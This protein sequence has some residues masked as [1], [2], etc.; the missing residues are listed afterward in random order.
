M[1]VGKQGS[2][3]VYESH[4]RKI[5]GRQKKE[6]SW[7]I[8][9]RFV[10][11]AGQRQRKKITG[12][13]KKE[14]E[15]VAAKIKMEMFA[16]EIVSLK[17]RRAYELTW[18]EL[19][20]EWIRFCS[21]TG[22]TSLSDDEQRLGRSVDYFG[23]ET[24]VHATTRSDVHAFRQWLL[25]QP[26]MRPGRPAGGRVEADSI[27]RDQL[28]PATV[29]R[30]VAACRA[31]VNHAIKADLLRDN[32]FNGLDPI[33][34][35]NK[36]DR[37]CTPAEYRRLLDNADGELKLLIEGL[38]ETGMRRGEL[39]S[40]RQANC[41]FERRMIYISPKS[42]KSWTARNVPMSRRLVDALQAAPV[43]AEGRY[44]Q[45]DGSTLTKA[46]KALAVRL[47]FDDLVLHDLRH[48]FATRMRREGVDPITVMRIC[49]WTSREVFDRY[50]S[51]N[52]KDRLAAVDGYSG[53]VG[54]LLD[55]IHQL[56]EQQQLISS[57]LTRVRVKRMT[58]KEFVSNVS[59]LFADHNR[60]VLK[61]LGEP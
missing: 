30:Y 8:D 53:D 55:K 29:N 43:D 45:S 47:K 56:E 39:V 52:D 31:A 5:P 24:P 57:W 59:D 38:Y 22:K 3:R 11:E 12:Y 15:V 61:A 21:S 32:P 17:D 10:D 26:R 50:N 2:V 54:V 35:H 33:R 48:T 13:T 34:E 20:E 42:S 40:L 36:R 16:G 1:K 41:D 58:E 4:P 9:I 14:A 19:F 23:A 7:G 46:F 27:K 18:Q 44:F 25:E 37:I 6:S 28:K 49:G 51:V 60:A